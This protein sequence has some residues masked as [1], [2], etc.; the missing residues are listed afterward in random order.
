MVKTQRA[1]PRSRT[2]PV[3]QMTTLPSTARDTTL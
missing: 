1:T 2:A 3:D